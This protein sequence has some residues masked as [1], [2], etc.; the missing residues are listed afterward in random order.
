MSTLTTNGLTLVEA[1]KRHDPD[2]NMATIAEVLMEDNEILQDAIW[3]EANDVFSNTTT[4]RSTLPSGSWRKLNSGVAAE[5]SDTIQVR[6]TIGILETFAKNDIEVIKSFKNP[7]QARS[8]E[9]MAFVEGLSQTMASTMIYG[10]TNTTPEKFTGLAPRLASLAT[11]TNV[12]NEGGSGSDLTSVFVV[13]W[14]PNKVCMLYPRN[15]NAGLEHEDMGK[16]LVT[17]IGS[18]EFVAYVDKFTWKAGMAVKN[19]KSIGRLANIEYTGASNTFDEDNLIT[20]MNR[21]TKG[22][23]RRIYSNEDIMTQAEIL[24]KDK[25][26]INFTVEHGLAPG[27]VLMFKK[28]PW[29]LV[30]RILN[31]ESALT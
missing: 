16:Q 30:D 8:D 23:G 22:P 3:R 10:N 21:M 7:A 2:G 13:D 1:A 12:L 20:L 17:D 5:K 11:T 15:S 9:A 31:T 24:L 25:T 19:E 14:A 18:Y 29:R 27:P 6:D 4:R 26:N 28:V